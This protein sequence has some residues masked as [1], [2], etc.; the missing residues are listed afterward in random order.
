MHVPHPDLKKGG[1]GER[2]CVGI[3]TQPYR[4]S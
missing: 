1:R 2:E 4:Q 3:I